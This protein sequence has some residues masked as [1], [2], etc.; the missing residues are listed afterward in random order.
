MRNGRLAAA[1]LCG[2]FL[3]APILAADPPKDLDGD[4]LP[5]G[6]FAGTLT[7]VPGTGGS[8]TMKAEFD[9]VQLKPGAGLGENRD[10]RDLIRD[11]ERV[12]RTQAEIAAARN[13]G[14]YNRL[15]RQL[16]GEL[17]HLE[18]QTARVQLRESGDYM[19]RKDFKDIDFHTSDDV[20]VRILNP[21]VQFDDKGN[22]KQYTPDEL[23]AMK[24]K[25]ADLPGYESTL[26]HLKV[27]DAIKVTLSTPK[28]AKDA[29]AKADP[30]AK[31]P[32]TITL[33]LIVSEDN[34]DKPKGKK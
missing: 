22:A 2:C 33:I 34:S 30:D 1:F 20:K 29:D 11:Q 13:R 26:D 3:A 7:T 5:P 25:D 23:K 12:E 32:N 27:G 6:Q 18:L 16:A 19:I 15:M 28:P 4:I 17:E 8:F 14:E 21:P 10:V 9:H 24:G 31:K